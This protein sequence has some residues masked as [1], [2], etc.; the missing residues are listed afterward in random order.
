MKGM[1]RYTLRCADD[2]TFESWFQSAAAYDA[3]RGSGH[4]ACPVCGNASVEKALMAPSVATANEPAAPSL[5]T[6]A[7]D[8][9]KAVAQLRR[10]VEENSEYVGL[11]F[12]AEARAMH[13]G[14]SPERA[15]YGEARI[16]DA[17]R[18]LEDGIPVTPLP[19]LTPRKAN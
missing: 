13:D 5:R 4:V 1:I 17:K 12:A 16:E 9:E 2:H 8:L 6:P 7:S 3:L 14:D 10:Q 11:N 15:I 19:F 18:L